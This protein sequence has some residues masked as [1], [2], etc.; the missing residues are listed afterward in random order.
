MKIRI[1]PLLIA[2]AV[3]LGP[4]GALRVVANDYYSSGGSVNDSWS[5]NSVPSGAVAYSDVAA[6]ADLYSYA[7]IQAGIAGPPAG[8]VYL[9]RVNVS[10]YS[11]SYD[12]K[13]ATLAGGDYQIWH[14][15]G[16]SGSGWVTAH[17][18]VSW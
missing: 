16:V 2:T 5:L 8:Q 3:M 6:F 1:V 12:H 18:N 17:T 10:S 7:T 11:T 14:G 13:D 9:A 4:I 15:G